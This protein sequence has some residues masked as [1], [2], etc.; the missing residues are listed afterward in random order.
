MSETATQRRPSRVREALASTNFR[1]LLGG[2]TVGAFG[3]AI[4]PVALAFAVLHLGGTASQL[5]LVVAAF[6]AAEVVTLLFGG[7]LGDRV[8]RQLMMQGSS[9]ATA[10][11]QGLM[12]LSLVAGFATIPMIGFIGVVNGCLGALSGP[13]SQAMT[14]QTV[15]EE[16]LPSAVALRRLSQQTAQVLGFAGAG[17]LV[18]AF[19]PGWAIAVD[20]ATFVVAGTCFTF[21]R[22]PRVT[23]EAKARPSL[24][25]ELREGAAEVFRHTWLWLLI[26][27]ALLYHLFYGGVQGVLGPIV[28]EDA[29]SEAAWGWALSALMAGF[30]LGGLVSLRWRPRRGLL[31]GTWLLA[32]TA[33]FPLAMAL[34]DNL[35]VLLLGAALHGFGLEVFSVNWDLSIQQNIADEKLARVYA[36]DMV[37]SFVA[38]PVGLALTGPISAVLG[39]TEWLVVVALIM[40]ASSLLA[41]F[42]P[43]VRALERR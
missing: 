41:T 10:A 2:T 33:A 4:T 18:A 25:A 19:G 17:V 13:S 27:Q 32:L 20:A 39:V 40:G 6:A 3:N 9:F 43:S 22:I 34:S 5:G 1:A 8:P 38:R 35:A 26:G 30:I 12:A 14:R 29:W 31:I 11:T 42:A 37:G 24:L 23:P 28:V 36:F 15:P 7:V 21:I 16:H